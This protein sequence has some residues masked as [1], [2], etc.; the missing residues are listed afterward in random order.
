MD[1][2]SSFNHTI[3]FQMA[4]IENNKVDTIV[5]EELSSKLKHLRYTT[6]IHMLLFVMILSISFG[7]ISYET[8]CLLRISLIVSYFWYLYKNV[9]YDEGSWTS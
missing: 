4:D 8:S 9:F 7:V 6:M 3:Q 1:T 5:D 2:L